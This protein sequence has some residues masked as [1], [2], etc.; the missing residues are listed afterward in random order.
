MHPNLSTTTSSK[1]TVSEASEWRRFGKSVFLGI[2]LPLLALFAILEWIAWGIGETMPPET[3]AAEQMQNPKLIWM[4]D[5]L[6]PRAR[7]KLARVAALRPDIL[8]IGQSRLTQ[9]RAA[10][11]Q[12]Y[13]CYNLT[14]ISYPVGTYSEILKHLPAGYTP[15]VIIVSTDFFSFS[16]LFTKTYAKM[17]PAFKSEGWSEHFNALNDVTNQI[18]QTPKVAWT[19]HAPFYGNPARG[20]RALTIGNGNRPDGSEMWPIAIVK[21]RATPTNDSIAAMLGRL[22]PG[23]AL[24]SVGAEEMK[25]FAEFVALAHSKGIAVV[26]VQ[27][28]MYMPTVRLLETDPTYTFLKDFRAKVSAGCFDQM[29]MPNFDYLSFPAYGEDYRYFGDPVHPSEPVTAAVLL[30]MAQDPRIAALLPKWDIQALLH[31][32]DANRDGAQHLYLPIDKP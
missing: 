29:G 26:G 14:C 1:P 15:K 9:M 25:A 24:N 18:L 3:V 4:A 8:I 16:P 19:R 22:I 30:S 2:M 5:R 13:S 32:L 17:P 28:P 7:F 12:P 27:M 6:G 21:N 10:M 11:F 20:L 23:G 31:L